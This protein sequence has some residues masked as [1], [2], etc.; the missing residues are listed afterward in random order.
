MQSPVKNVDRAFLRT[1]SCQAPQ[2]PHPV[3]KFQQILIPLDL[4]NDYSVS[5]HH[6]ICLA[7]TFRSTVNLLHLYEEPYVLN[8][9]PR[10]RN[11]D[12]FKL[13]RQRVFVEFYNLLEKTRNVYSDSKGFFEYGNPDHD[14]CKIARQLEADLLILCTHNGRWIQHR[15]FGSHAERIL[16]SAPCPV[17]I[18]CEKELSS[19]LEKPR[20]V[21]K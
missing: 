2:A 11:C 21:E 6:A 13:Q 12:V 17:L 5:I 19:L 7:K 18:V 14:I 15:V 3:V 9:S 20:I 8:H 1:Q 10:S 4:K 16:E